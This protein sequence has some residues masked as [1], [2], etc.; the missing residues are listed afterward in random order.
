MLKLA[1][2]C[3]WAQ[4]GP[5]RAALRG[6][7]LTAAATGAAALRLP[8][9]RDGRWASPPRAPA[10]AAA[11]ISPSAAAIAAFRSCSKRTV[12]NA[13]SVSPDSAAVA[14][15]RAA[16]S[17]IVCCPLAEQRVQSALSAKRSVRTSSPAPAGQ[18]SCAHQP[19]AS[20]SWASCG[21]A[22]GVHTTSHASSQGSG[23]S[24]PCT[25]NS[26]S[27]TRI[28]P[29]SS[30]C[31]TRTRS[32]RTYGGTATPSVRATRAIT[33]S[34]R[35]RTTSAALAS[36]GVRCRLTI[37]SLPPRRGAR[38]G[39]LHAGVICKLVPRQ[40]TRSA[41]SVSCLERAMSSAGSSLSQ[42]RHWSRSAPRQ[43]SHARPVCLSP[44][45][46]TSKSRT[47]S[48][49][50]VSHTSRKQLPCSSASLS[51]G[52]PERMCRQSTFWLTTRARRPMRCSPTRTM[53]VSEG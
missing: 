29:S 16:R 15:A 40:R 46:G 17:V 49:R 33:A 14:L 21:S 26:L 45:E 6:R 7:A 5:D 19:P 1:A 20:E 9:T 47:Y 32:T 48:R 3:M 10:A 8:C 22:G 25:L 39:M 30:T 52:S 28:P 4:A 12:S 44:T 35:A 27:S 2:S 23:A 42:S 43:C 37:T 53:C 41:L 11:V 38:S 18:C 13:S 24:S 51:R 36:L 50:H 31:R 34:T